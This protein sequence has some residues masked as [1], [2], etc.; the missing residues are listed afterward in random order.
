MA[1]VDISTI[2]KFNGQNYSQWRFQLVCALKAKGVFSIANGIK[3]KPD[4]DEAKIEKWE[5]EDAVAMFTISSAMDLSQVTLIESCTSSKE[6]L[7]K[8]DSIFKLKS[9]FNKMLLLDKFHQIKIESNETVVQYIAKIENLAHQIKDTGESI[10]DATIIT[11]ILGTLPPKY[12]NFRQAWLSVDESK[13]NLSNLTARLIDEETSLSHSEQS[14]SAFFTSNRPKFDQKKPTSN[15]GNENRRKNHN[16]SVDKSKITC[17]TCR[18]KGHYARDCRSKPREKVNDVIDQSRGSSS[19]SAFNSEVGKYVKSEELWILDSGASAHMSYNLNYFNNFCESVHNEVIRLGNNLELPIKGRG[20]IN[21][22]R[23]INGKWLGGE[24][25]D[26]LYVPDL[27]KNLLSEGVMASKGMKIIKMKN[28]ADIYNCEDELIGTAVRSTNNLYHMLFKTASSPEANISLK[29]NLKVWHQRTGHINLKAL[30]ELSN[31]GLIE[32]LDIS[33]KDEFFCEGCQYGK[34]HR[35]PFNQKEYKATKPAELIYSDIC[36]PM[37]VQSV[38]GANYFILMKDDFSGFRTVNFLKHKSDALEAFQNFVQMCENKFGHQV[39]ALRVDNGTEYINLC[40]NDFLHKK[41]IQLETTAPY[42][43]QQ[44]GRSE[45]DMRTIV[46]SA[47]SMIYSKEVP[48]YLWAEAVNTAVYVL[49]RTPTSQAPNSTPYELWTGKSLYLNHLRI[50]GS[51]AYMHV[52]D[53]L[54]KKLEP[55]SKKMIFVGYDKESTNYRLFDPVTKTIKVS[56]NVVFNEENC[57]LNITPPPSTFPFTIDDDDVNKDPSN[58]VSENQCTSPSASQSDSHYNFRPRNALKPPA[59]YDLNIADILTPQTY[60]EAISSPQAENWKEAIND[61]LNSLEK[62]QTWELVPLPKDSNVIGSK[63]VFKIKHLPNGKIDRFKARLCAKGFAQMEGVDFSETF[64]PTSRFDTI[65]VILALAVQR[66]WKM[67]QIDVKTAF[68]YGNIDETIFMQPPPGLDVTADLVC[69]LKRSLYGLKQASRCWNKTFS[70]F[71]TNYGFKQSSAEPCIFNGIFKGKKV[72]LIL[73][74]DDAL[75]FC[76]E[77]EILI[78][79]VNDFKIK[80]EAT[81]CETGCFVGM[82]IDYKAD[83][84]IMLHSESYVKRILKRF[85]LDDASPN[86][87]PADPGTILSSESNPFPEGKTVPYR[88]AVGSLMFLASTTRPDIAFA[89]NL[90]SRFQNNPGQV[91]WNAVKR[92]FRYLKGTANY[93]IEYSPVA[94]NNC[95]LV[96]YSDSDFANDVDTRKSTSGY[97]FKIS[98]GPV[99]WSSQKQ[100]TVSTST[101]ESE[102]I[103]ASTAVKETLWLKQLLQDV[104]ESEIC[105]EGVTL[106][107]DNQSAVKLIKN[108]VFHKRT[109]HIDVRYHFIREKYDD[110]SIL[111]KYIKSEEQLADIFTKALPKTKFEKLRELLN[112][113]ERLCV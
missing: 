70:E 1:S 44:N 97:V 90:V 3:M 69:K 82:E 53:V 57:K 61:E 67:L 35:F 50:F 39:K 113:K 33:E 105:K 42:T 14:E 32:K 55:K 107:I 58:D 2:N 103:A 56:R 59:R 94:N 62:N 22:Q 5:K 49:N 91:H 73:Y 30:C 96:G 10:S 24:I 47:R 71:L 102:Y 45:R 60:E 65:R 9:D 19:Y 52:P 100:S 80:F 63:W 15:F 75:L 106:F 48:L 109:K 28:Q 64:S 13:Q 86:T 46:E 85:Y 27:K 72:L 18:K 74:V 93:G 51:E 26:V 77:K 43:P 41:G 104:G 92:I 4:S 36:G 11:K 81:I 37:S 23:L 25:N 111:V 89:V 78:E 112:I 40:F 17:Y 20:N 87:T 88:E 68:L 95:H 34:Q 98:N 110:G 38:G 21:I 66:K 16:K 6:M 12:R 7:E 29:N 83:G 8:L 84:T 99:T 108:P 79:I 101:T 54:R 76:E 31:R